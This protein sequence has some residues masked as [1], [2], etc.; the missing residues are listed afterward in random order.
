MNISLQWLAIKP[1]HTQEEFLQNVLIDMARNGVPTDAF[2]ANISTVSLVHV[3]IM[4]DQMSVKV[5]YRAV[6]TAY[7]YRVFTD[8]V[9]IDAEE[10]YDYRNISS[11]TP[12]KS[13]DDVVKFIHSLNSDAFVGVSN[14]KISTMTK[15]MNSKP[16]SIYNDFTDSIEPSRCRRIN[17]S[18]RDHLPTSIGYCNIKY[19]IISTEKSVTT[20]YLLPMYMVNITYKDKTYRKTAFVYDETITYDV[21]RCNSIT[22]TNGLAYELSLLDAKEKDERSKHT[23]EEYRWNAF[24]I[25]LSVVAGLCILSIIISLFVR[26]VGVI[27]ATFAVPTIAFVLCLIAIK[28]TEDSI[29]KKANK[30]YYQVSLHKEKNALRKQYQ[31]ALLSALNKKLESLGFDPVDHF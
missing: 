5:S 23:E 8:T 9:Q 24:K 6:E 25:P 17:M 7:P 18:I 19:D 13:N 21:Y 10:Y 3:P 22:A 14:D 26:S 16:R 29:F 20:V 15:Y 28:K 27:I 31:P 30:A 1:S 2:D 12:L 11:H 4:I